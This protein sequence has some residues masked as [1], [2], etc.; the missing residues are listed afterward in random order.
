MPKGNGKDFEI[1]C[2]VLRKLN[3][4][5]LKLWRKE[6]DLSGSDLR[7]DIKFNYDNLIISNHPM[8]EKNL[9]NLIKQ[10]LD[11]LCLAFDESFYLPP[12]DDNKD[13]IPL[14]SLNC[15]LTEYP[16]EISLRIC[17]YRYLNGDITKPQGIGFRF[18][19]H[20]GSNHDYYHVQVTNKPHASLEHEYH[21]WIPEN[22]PCILQP[23]QNPVSLIFSMLISFYGKRISEQMIT[24]MNIDRKY[25]EPLKFIQ[26]PK[27]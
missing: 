27:D 11:S 18:E 17:M 8:Q 15:N 3:D 20:K 6:K 13:F 9:D 5:S 1:M 25:K 19:K 12:L 14:L 22:I 21:D 7:D 24:L 26:T 23:A 4:L 16:P 10:N 2:Q